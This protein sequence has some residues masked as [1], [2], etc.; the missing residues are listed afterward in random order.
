VV[1]EFIPESAGSANARLV[2]LGITSLVGVYAT[3]QILSVFSNRKFNEKL[4]TDEQFSR[5]GWFISRSS[6]LCM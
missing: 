3:G 5:D 2:M 6:Q 4:L 1:N